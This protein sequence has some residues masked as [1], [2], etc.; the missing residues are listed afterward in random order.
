[1]P[2]RNAC[3]ISYRHGQH[4]LMGRFVEQLYE[5]L[6]SELEAVTDLRI[7]LDKSRLQGGDL[8]NPALARSLCESACMIMIFTQTYFSQEHRYCAREFAAMC[9]LER[10]RMTAG[11]EHGLIIP[12]VLRRFEA[13]PRSISSKRQVYRF[14]KYTVSGR[15]LI[16][17][18]HF[19]A[20]IQK[21]ARYIADRVQELRADAI[22][23]TDFRL[24]DDNDVTELISDMESRSAAFPGRERSL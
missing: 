21:M 18:R 1:M 24:P 4:E 12:V 20:D 5:A 8:Y 22:D 17:N 10:K 11:A 9:E 13:L 23:C 14:E 6:A 19:D 2:I 15:R 7:Y 3:F 16:L